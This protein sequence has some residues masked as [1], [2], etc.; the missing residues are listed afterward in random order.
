MGLIGNLLSMLFVGGKVVLVSPLTF[1]QKLANCLNTLHRY[2]AH[3]TG[4]PNFSYDLCVEKIADA[5]IAGTSL[6][7]LRVAFNGAEPIRKNPWIT[8]LENSE[9]IVLIKDRSFPVMGWLKGHYL[10]LGN[11]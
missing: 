1:L 3:I 8:S 11:P 10:L 7:T 6:K 5:D 9:N 2:N 4:G